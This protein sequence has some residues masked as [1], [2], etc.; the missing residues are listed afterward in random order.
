M[1]GTY[2]E[3]WQAGSRQ[4][5]QLIGRVSSDIKYCVIYTYTPEKEVKSMEKDLVCGMEVD[6][7]TAPA[8]SIYMGK[9]YYFCSIDCKQDFDKEPQ[10]YITAAMRDMKH[11]SQPM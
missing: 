3:V 11:G 6:P 8:K 7:K 9:T 5:L 1:S 10:K 2:L 4:V